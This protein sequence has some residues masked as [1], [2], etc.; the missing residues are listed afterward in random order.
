MILQSPLIL[1][2]VLCSP[3]FLPF[4]PEMLCSFGRRNLH[5]PIHSFTH[6]SFFTIHPIVVLNTEC[7]AIHNAICVRF[8]S[9][10]CFLFELK[11]T[12]GK[13]K[14]FS[15]PFRVFWLRAKIHMY[16]SLFTVHL[17]M[18][19]NEGAG[20]P[21]LICADAVECWPMFCVTF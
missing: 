12:K 13:K 20:C 6:F 11:K 7:N 19:R 17:E 4:H 5:T 18:I 3:S 8:V 16:F 21:I 9:Y 14:C 2:V 10:S 1:I 15:S